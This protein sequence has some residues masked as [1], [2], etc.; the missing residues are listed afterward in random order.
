MPVTT[1]EIAHPVNTKLK[2][3]ASNG[4]PISKTETPKKG[5]ARSAAGTIPI[6]VRIILIDARESISSHGRKG[7]TKRFPRFLD[8]ISSKKDKV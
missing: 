3:K 2:K 1:C 8:H 6:K 5:I 4:K 7:A